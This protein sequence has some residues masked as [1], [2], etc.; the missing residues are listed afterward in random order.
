MLKWL[1]MQA[2][3]RM[4][5][6]F[7]FLSLTVI[8]LTTYFVILFAKGYRPSLNQ[9][10]LKPT[11]I[12][13]LTSYP[14]GAQAYINGTLK[15]ATNSTVNLD[16]GSYEIEIKKEG[17]F[18]WKK[19]LL[20]EKEIVTRAT[21][22]LFP[23]IPILKATTS[24]GVTHP[25]LS[26]SGDKIAFIQTT[27]K[28]AYLTILEMGESPLGLIS[29]EPRAVTR[30]SDPKPANYRLIW[31]YDSREVLALASS[32]ATLVNIFTQAVSEASISYPNLLSDWQNHRQFSQKQLFDALPEILKP[33]LATAAADISWSPNEKKLLYTATASA[34]L[35]DQIKKPLPGSSTQPQ[36]RL[37]SP[38]G[39]YIFD[40]EEDRNFQIDTAKN[41]GWTWFP[42]SS[43][44]YKVIKDLV[45][46]KE[47]DNGNETVIYAGPLFENFAVPYPSG[48]QFLILTNPTPNLIPS[49]TSIP[50]T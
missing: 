45:V 1:N 43:H 12:L 30:L 23:N 50:L 6:F 19:Q 5:I 42:S 25:V 28:I 11:G 49:P 46:V 38:G 31:S 7:F 47:Y 37:L 15:T 39:V 41:S 33:I 27:D 32:S 35:P 36:N 22:T 10:S 17:F 29:R 8:P 44:I 20:I 14:D 3:V 24:Q 48:K 26:P 9:T 34:S 13:V 21:A 18:P 2:A 16:P 4:R 40:L